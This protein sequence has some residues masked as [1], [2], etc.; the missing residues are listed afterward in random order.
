MHSFD[1]AKGLTGWARDTGS[2]MSTILMRALAL[3]I[4]IGAIDYLVTR[5]RL[6][7]QL[8]MSKQELK[9]EYK[10]Y[11]GDPHVKAAR[12][13]RAQELTRN[14][15]LQEVA[16]ADVV[17]MNPTH[18]AVALV[19]T[20][21]DVAPKVVAMGRNFMA[22]KIRTLAHRNGVLV[23]QDP[24]LARALY[25]RCKLGQYVPAA[26]YEAVAVVIA[27]AFRRRMRGIA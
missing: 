5:R 16:T 17:I 9:E 4:A 12:R 21:G 1:E 3:S 2:L 23:Q 18:Y 22:L 19:Y 26:L 10:Q 8:R 27:A 25:R 20:D 7:K 24:P 14:R 13:R 15:M 11:E 6:N